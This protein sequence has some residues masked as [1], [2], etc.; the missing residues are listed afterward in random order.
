MHLLHRDYSRNAMTEGNGAGFYSD[1]TG[2][3]VKH[4][5]ADNF[6]NGLIRKAES[7]T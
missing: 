4:Y 7:T 5:V 2:L 6:K 1:M 3:N